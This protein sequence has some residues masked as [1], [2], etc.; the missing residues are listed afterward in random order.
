MVAE[1]DRLDELVEEGRRRGDDVESSPSTFASAIT[2][3]G[4]ARCPL[5]LEVG[6]LDFLVLLELEGGT[7]VLPWWRLAAASSTRL[8]GG[9]LGLGEQ[10]SCTPSL[11]ASTRAFHRG[12]FGAPFCSMPAAWEQLLFRDW[13]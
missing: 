10:L 13:A 8:L 9:P 12:G 2:W 11:S 3:P 6:E 7:L 4:S 5:H 1:R